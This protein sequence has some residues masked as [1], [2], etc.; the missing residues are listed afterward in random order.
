MF[1][2]TVVGWVEGGGPDLNVRIHSYPGSMMFV[3]STY[4]LIL[5]YSIYWMFQSIFHCF[6]IIIIVETK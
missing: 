5:R 1:Y 6:H 3:R 4:A 2:R